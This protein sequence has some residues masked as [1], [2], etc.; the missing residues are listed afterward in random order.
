MFRNGDSGTPRQGE[1][2]VLPL[3]GTI[4]GIRRKL[5]DRQ[6][7][8]A[9][10]GR[11]LG[12]GAA[13]GGARHEQDAQILVARRPAGNALRRGE[14]PRQGGKRRNAFGSVGEKWSPGPAEA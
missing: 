12:M 4:A 8:V 6:M 11:G 7:P 9:I 13:D 5:G 2:H 3:R 14:K 10:Q 1:K